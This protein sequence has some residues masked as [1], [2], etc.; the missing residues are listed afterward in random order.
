MLFD[1]HAHLDFVEDLDESL[2]Q[3]QKTG[4]SK[5]ISIGTNFKESKAAIKI[6][7]KH[8][9]K[10]LEIFTSCGI[11]PHDGKDDVKNGWIDKLRLIANSS[12]KI[13]AIGEC[14]L[15]YYSPEDKRREPIDE[16]KKFQKEVFVKQ[17]RLANELNLPII[18]HCRDS[19]DDILDIIE[20]NKANTLTGVFHSWTGDLKAMKKALGLGFY[21]SFSGIVTFKNAGV[22]QEVAKTV[23]LNKFLIRL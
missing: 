14:G 7:Q 2:V 17:I 1:S 6:A 10:D 3:A 12:D 22:I 16:S 23:P 21:I 20:K 18:V 9:K 13:I 19:W 11:H 4:V 5:I 15:D 8:S